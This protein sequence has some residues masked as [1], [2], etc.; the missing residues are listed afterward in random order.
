MIYVYDVLLNFNDNLIEFYNWDTDDNIYYI[1][2]IPLFKVSDSFINDIIYNTIE[3]DDLFI[4]SIKN[5]CL[6]YDNNSINACILSSD[7]FSI[8]ILIKN[9]KIDKVSRMI[10]SEEDEVF[11][12]ISHLNTNIIKYNKLNKIDRNIN[13]SSK[14]KNIL[15][16][17]KKEFNYLYNNNE[18]EKLN[19]YYF[20]YFNKVCNDKN[21]TYNELI[22][23]LI[24]INDKHKY[25]YKIIKLSYQNKD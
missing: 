18:I 4:T 10:L 2:K 1:K 23:S 3:L 8:G 25:L 15:D 24:D 22:N 21:I 13:I 16:I 5:K 20:E 7:V 12:I 11:N 6:L 19:Y 9:N 14:D 17:L